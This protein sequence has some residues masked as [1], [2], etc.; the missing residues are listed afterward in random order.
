MPALQALAGDLA[1]ENETASDA[2][3]RPA[4]DGV[5]L[6]DQL[7]ELL[8]VLRNSDMQ[9]MELHAT[10]RQSCPDEL[11][12]VFEPLDA[13]MAELDFEKATIECETLVAQ[14]TQ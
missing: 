14:L 10:L 3:A 7:S 13:A 9:A 5:N 8:E 6:L 1:Q 11:A 4:A 12:D 2:P